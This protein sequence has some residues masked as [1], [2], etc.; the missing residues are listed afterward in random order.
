M[1]CSAIVAG[2]F[3][4][5]A[6]AHVEAAAP[7]PFRNCQV[8]VDGHTADQPSDPVVVCRQLFPAAPFVR[9]PNDQRAANGQVTLYGVVEL[10][11]NSDSHIRNARFYDRALKVYGLLG[12]GGKPID[13]TSELMKKKHLPS[14]RVHFLVYEA[15]GTVTAPAALHLTGLRPV[16]LVE[17]QASTAVSPGRGKGWS[18][19]GA[20]LRS[21]TRI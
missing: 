7:A 16:I 3:L 8:Q 19:G 4:L 18:P 11:I 13:E 9:L 20:R 5:T 15:T 10:D 2:L 17:G 14:N 12:S 6:A 1:T 21:G